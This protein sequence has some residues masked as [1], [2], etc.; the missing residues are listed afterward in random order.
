M[1]ISAKIVAAVSIVTALV[2]A[3]GAALA[4][5]RLV[6]EQRRAF[7]D[8]KREAIELLAVAIAPSLREGSHHQ[9]Q[10]VLDNVANFPERYPDVRALEVVDLRGRVFAHFD[11]RRYG[12][13][14][15]GIAEGALATATPMTTE[16]GNGELE[17]SVPV[18]LA[19]PLGLL[20]ARV[21]E[22]RLDAAVRRQRRAAGLLVLGA[23]VPIGVL[24]Y[25]LYRRDTEVAHARRRLAQLTSTHASASSKG[26]A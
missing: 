12:T 10:A 13:P 7:F 20:R 23:M 11:P 6:V 21:D 2:G 17:V 4:I 19:H 25:L 24:L 5:D 14:A 9:A 18:R 22:A 16:L 8:A 1:T 26:D 3:L 15:R